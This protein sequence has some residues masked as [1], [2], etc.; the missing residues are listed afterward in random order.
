MDVIWWKQAIIYQIYPRSFCD[1]NG[2]GIGDLRG[3]ISKIDYLV[4]LGIRAVWLNPVYD[5]P[6]DDM[7]YDIRDYNAIMREFGSIE[8]MEYLIQLL[9]KNGIRIIMDLVIN[10][11]SDEHPWFI[12][13]RS[14]KESKTRDYYIWR[15]GKGKSEPNN[16]AS[17]FTPSAWTY[18]K[19]TDQYYLHI[20][21]E[22]QPDLNWNN[23][24]L[25]QEIKSM[26]H[27]WFSRG[28]D[29]FRM[30]A[31][32]LIAKNTKLPNHWGK[33]NDQGYVFSYNSIANQK[34]LHQYLREI[35]RECFEPYEG[36]CVGETPH[37]STH[38]GKKLANAHRHELDMIFQ[39]QFIEL[40]NI[41]KR[42]DFP[43]MKFKKLVNRWQ[44]ALD[45]NSL[46]WGNHDQPRIVS[47]L[48]DTSSS[49][50][51]KKSAKMLALMLYC[52][53][54]T[55]FLYQG[56]ELGMTNVPFQKPDDIRDIQAIVM[57]REAKKYHHSEKTWNDILSFGRDNARTPLHWNSLDK[58]GFTKG[59][60]WIMINPNYH[61]IN[62]ESE[63]A[64]PDSIL[65][66]YRKLIAL[67]QENPVFI[68]GTF[69]QI[70]RWHP[71]IFAYTRN[72]LGKQYA[73]LCNF[74]SKSFILKLN[75]KFQGGKVLLSNSSNPIDKFDEY[76][77]KVIEF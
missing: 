75:H 66:F 10:H 15:N 63:L 61:I 44:N 7:G 45:W 4:L 33:S 71:N 11:T 1:S 73:V 56:E 34:K 32:N 6:N 49:S 77:A 76:E 46:F 52:Q 17:H 3:I 53:K 36:M 74:T 40:A 24:F 31:I 41:A 9:H 26:I 8:D 18:D 29:G 67:R 28:I 14:S 59:T 64:D 37:I 5:S 57:I 72:Y 38:I 12:E 51:W 58:A 47:R 20:F 25:R 13:S 23:S 21:S 54:G 55:P 65:N 62:V 48:G 27:T 22:K 60:P 50:R 35:K 19:N 39:N 42:S 2:D 69:R 70:Y 16:W 43:L 68:L 30:D